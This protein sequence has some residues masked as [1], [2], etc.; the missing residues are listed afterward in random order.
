MKRKLL[1]PEGTKDYLQEE[2]YIQRRLIGELLEEFSLWGYEEIKTPMIEKWD[3]V[4]K[5]DIAETHYFT[6]VDTTGDLLVLRPEITAPAARVVATHFRDHVTYPLRLSYAG[7]VF[8]Q[9]GLKK[10]ERRQK[11][12]VGI[13]LVGADSISSDCEVLLM[14]LES[15]K[16]NEIKGYSLGIGHMDITEGLLREFF[17]DEEARVEVENLMMNKDLVSLDA[18]MEGEGKEKLLALVATNGG[19]EFIQRIRSFSNKPAFQSAISRLEKIYEILGGLG[20]ADRIFFD[21]SILGDF[22]YYT[23]LLF[24]G[25][26]NGLGMPILR[27]GRY[28]N[29]VEEYYRKEPAVGFALYPDLYMATMER[30]I[31][32]PAVEEVVSEA[33]ILKRFREAEKLRNSGKKVLI[34]LEEEG[35]E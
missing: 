11:T 23:G 4:K 5:K 24:E 26:S 21:F 18:M 17:P 12:Q 22:R 29:L 15:M 7:E 1:I 35:H 8:S 33:D 10:G 2:A 25:Y 31:Q 34:Q 20:F 19:L 9:K 27:G 13:E 32:L 6:L 3:I 14:A 30:R 28:D 16:A